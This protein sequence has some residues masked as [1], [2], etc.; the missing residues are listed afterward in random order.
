MGNQKTLEERAK[1]KGISLKEPTEG[2]YTYGDLA[3]T[4]RSREE[5]ENSL[6]TRGEI[7][8][9]TNMV[10]WRYSEDTRPVKITARAYRPKPE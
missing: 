8:G 7:F 1:E 2:D 5:A 3:S 6:L 10:D 4:G 9:V